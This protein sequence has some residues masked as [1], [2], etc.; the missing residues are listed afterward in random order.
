MGP[1]HL[2]PAWRLVAAAYTIAR[3]LK[4]VFA[5]ERLGFEMK[6]RRIA[7]PETRFIPC[8]SFSLFFLSYSYTYFLVSLF[9]RCRFSKL[10][11]REVFFFIAWVHYLSH[12]HNNIRANQRLT[13]RGVKLPCQVNPES[14]KI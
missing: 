9:L 2:S 4:S 5:T 1:T 12:E 13:E 14:S 6:G 3:T 7:R 10:F 8:K 11:W